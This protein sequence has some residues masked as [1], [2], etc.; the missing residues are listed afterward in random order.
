MAALKNC[1]SVTFV[2]TSGFGILMAPYG[3]TDRRL[4]ANPIAIGI[5]IE[6]NDYLVDVMDKIDNATYNLMKAYFPLIR[7]NIIPTSSFCFCLSIV[8]QTR[9]TSSMNK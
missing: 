2:N 7:K 4:S 5:P 3:G 8:N 9:T 6:N 1:V